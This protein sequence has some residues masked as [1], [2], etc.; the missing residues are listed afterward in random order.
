MANDH[1]HSTWARTWIV[2]LARM[3]NSDPHLAKLLDDDIIGFLTA[4]NGSGQPQTAP[5]WFLRQGEDLIVYNRTGTPRLES[6]AMN[7][8]VSFTLRADAKGDAMATLEGVARV[9]DGLPL[10]KDLDGYVDKYATSIADL[11]WTPESFSDDYPV[12]LRITVTRVRS[13]G[14]TALVD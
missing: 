1:G 11:G 2:T 9:D 10:A 12:G 13:F 8:K 7:S 3:I 6:I 14:L 4:V 5:V